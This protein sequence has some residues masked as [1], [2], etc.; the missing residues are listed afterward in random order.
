MRTRRD[1]GGPLSESPRLQRWRGRGA[2][3]LVVVA[4]SVGGVPAPTAGA[5]Y[6][7]ADDWW[8]PA[9][10]ATW[11]WQLTGDVDTSI[12]VDVFDLDLFETQP[13]TVS[14]LHAEGRRVICYVSVGTVENWRPDA[15]TF[16][17]DVVGEA[18]AEWEG[19]RWLD[20]RQIER[21]APVLRR[22]LDL[23]R[24][25]GFD[26]VEPDNIDGFTN[27]TGFD[28]SRDEAARFLRW[29]AEEAH[30]RE[31]SV[32]LKNAPELASLVG[33]VDWAL[34]ED[35]AAEGWC[36]EMRPFIAAGKPVFMAEY[37]DETTILRFER[38]VCPLAAELGFSA[39][40]QDRDLDA[41]RR[42]CPAA[43]RMPASTPAPEV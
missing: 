33:T 8:R 29:L 3:F 38:E 13:E 17:R 40:L 26:G 36:A 30:A 7:A 6:Q 16:P 12:N 11:Q 43:V 27:E 35:C 1:R 41:P 42:G 22:R 37:T 15:G 9:V 20:V 5:P 34:T 24:E 28:I 23:C 2:V 31:L 19:E 18:Y 14:A 4:L 32:G 10:G 25:K 21:L 39:I